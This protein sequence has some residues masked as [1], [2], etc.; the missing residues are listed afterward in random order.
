MRRRSAHVRTVD[1]LDGWLVGDQPLEGDRVVVLGGGRAGMGLA[2]LAS[3]Q[4]KD[5]TV[6]EASSV[7]AP[8]IG[9]VARWR[10]VHELQA[11]GV[12]LLNDTTVR[13]IDASGVAV[14]TGDGAR[15]LAA[16]A[17]ARRVAYRRP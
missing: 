9:L 14:T 2:D 11:R 12:E 16:D 3:Q 1:E 8:Q 4:G 15:V 6:V 10:L 5:V 7:F 17:R 13:H